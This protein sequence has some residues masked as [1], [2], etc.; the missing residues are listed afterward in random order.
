VS[1]TYLWPASFYTNLFHYAEMIRNSAMI[2]TNYGGEDKVVWVSP[3]DIAEAAAEE[4]VRLSVDKIRY[5]AS[6][7]RTC[8]EVVAVLGAAIGRPNLQWRSF[9]DEQV[10]ATMEQCGVPPLT[11]GLLVNLNA[12]I[13][14]GLMREDYDRHAPVMGK[15]KMENFARKF[16]LAFK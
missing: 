5:V 7:E 2:A 1:I 8:N 16:A 10:K 6:D 3:L 14:T 11:A 4:L 13:A 15:V 12:A 9:S